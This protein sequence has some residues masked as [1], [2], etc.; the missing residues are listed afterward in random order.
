M[1]QSIKQRVLAST[2]LASVAS[3]ITWLATASFPNGTKLFVLQEALVF[4]ILCFLVTI[5][6][7]LV[8]VAFCV[9]LFAVYILVRIVF[10]TATF[11]DFLNWR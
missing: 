2:I 11:D 8:I 4:I 7:G 5:L 6:V 3:F 1:K 9:I 10:G